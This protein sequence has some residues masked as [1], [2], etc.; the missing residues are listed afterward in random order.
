M[1]TAA[2][3]QILA[4]TR[5]AFVTKK[6]A[7]DKHSIPDK[8][9]SNTARSLQ[10]VLNHIEAI[11]E[12][13][14]LSDH[15]KVEAVGAL[16]KG[17]RQ[18]LD[19][20]MNQPHPEEG[21]KVEARHILASRLALTKIHNERKSAEVMVTAHAFKIHGDTYGDPHYRHR[22]ANK[23]Q[24]RRNG[25]VYAEEWTHEWRL[26]KYL[27][28]SDLIDWDTDHCERIL[29]YLHDH[30]EAAY[31]R[32][33]NLYPDFIE[34]TDETEI[35]SSTSYD[36]HHQSFGNCRVTDRWI[37]SP[38]MP[39]P[40]KPLPGPIRGTLADRLPAKNVHKMFQEHSDKSFVLDSCFY[41]VMC[42]SGLKD[43]LESTNHNR[44][45]LTF[46]GMIPGQV[47][48]RVTLQQM[49]DHVFKPML[50]EIVGYFR[51]GSLAF[52]WHP[53]MMGINPVTRK[54]YQANSKPRGLVVV[55]VHGDH[56]T[57]V[58]HMNTRLPN[59]ERRDLCKPLKPPREYMKVPVLTPGDNLKPVVSCVED[60]LP[61]ID[62]ESLRSVRLCYIKDDDCLPLYF[63]LRQ[64]G[65]DPQVDWN[66]LSITLHLCHDGNSKRIT[67]V[68]PNTA[69]ERALKVATAEELR[70]LDEHTCKIGNSLRNNGNVCSQE[71]LLYATYALRRPQLRGPLVPYGPEEHL[72]GFDLVK[73]FAHHGAQADHHGRFTEFDDLVPWDGEIRATDMYL[74]VDNL[75]P[76]APWDELWRGQQVGIFDGDTVMHPV[77]LGFRTSYRILGMWRPSSLVSNTSGTT[78]G[79]L[80][81]D[82]ELR[83]VLKKQPPNSEHGKAEIVWA[84]SSECQAY[85]TLEQAMAMCIR[86]PGDVNPRVWKRL[87][88]HEPKEEEDSEKSVTYLVK[89]EVRKRLRNGFYVHKHRLYLSQLCFQKYLRS[90]MESCGLQ[91]VRYASDCTY[92][93]ETRRDG[94]KDFALAYPEYFAEPGKGFANAG[95]IRPELVRFKLDIG[96]E[97]DPKGPIRV[98]LSAANHTVDE[99]RIKKFKLPKLLSERNVMP[100]RANP[101]A[102]EITVELI[103]FKLRISKQDDPR[104]PVRVAIWVEHLAVDDPTFKLTVS[105]KDVMPIRV[106]GS[107][108]T[109]SKAGRNGEDLVLTPK[110]PHPNVKICSNE[111]DLQQLVEMGTSACREGFAGMESVFAGGRKSAICDEV[112]KARGLQKD[113]VLFVCYDHATE[114][115]VRTRH[116]VWNMPDWRVCSMHKFVGRTPAHV[117]VD[118]T[119]LAGVKAIVF[120][121]L[122]K[123]DTSLI[124]LANRRAQNFAFGREVD[125]SS[126]NDFGIQGT[127][128]FQE[129]RNWVLANYDT[130]QISPPGD[131]P[132]NVKDY[133][134][135]RK[136][137]VFGSMFRTVIYQLRNK[138]WPADCQHMASSILVDCFGLALKRL[139]RKVPDD[140]DN[141]L[142]Q[143]DHEGLNAMDW[144]NK[145]AKPIKRLEDAPENSQFVAY[146]RDSVS[147]A[148]KFLSKGDFTVEV[149]DVLRCRDRTSVKKVT[150]QVGTYWKVTHK[151]RKDTT[152]RNTLYDGPATL[153]KCKTDDEKQAF[154]KNVVLIDSRNTK[155]LRHF[156]LQSAITGHGMMGARTDKPLV[157]MDLK[158]LCS[159]GDM[160]TANKWI[161]TTLFRVHHPQQLYYLDEPLNPP[162]FFKY[163]N[164]KRIA[165]YQ[166][167]D[168]KA[169]RPVHPLTSKELFGVFKKQNRFCAAPT[170]FSALDEATMVADR[171]DIAIG[172]K[173]DNLQFCCHGCNASLGAGQRHLPR[174]SAF[175]TDESE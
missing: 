46:E 142:T 79:A 2:I 83:P 137:M 32:L 27:V 105:K 65:Y 50:W 93:R 171:K 16:F 24:I 70:R 81:E 40:V 13:S 121:E 19:D 90:R 4:Q 53:S 153:A 157:I 107:T 56:V 116:R 100:I 112:C 163:F 35:P 97:D 48:G 129:E 159:G 139:L 21:K 114:E 143:I 156:D 146:M 113:E 47:G 30:D 173:L 61:Y 72:F 127:P 172:H 78:I 11:N 131:V 119:D 117:E 62:D 23:R 3:K 59:G 14:S 109:I 154:A 125:E 135:Y 67:I 91:V 102:R 138:T 94:L 140:I 25:N 63:K 168:R 82:A 37:D 106:N 174:Q 17:H 26:P 132:N 92:F 115:T 108:V 110:R 64:A 167:Q 5:P 45:S 147:R 128:I 98:Y 43:K 76:T 111:D 170:C 9:N 160:R 80:W 164:S 103:R 29:V 84:K 18:W 75:F 161:M 155:Q 52:H 38:Y 144:I 123:S 58:P 69:E 145:Y 41:K 169:G 57:A 162:Q 126:P 165:S 86:K 20:R 88:C 101:N 36:A 10:Y 22:L 158:W 136:D 33:V 73:S 15:E 89:E 6:V 95:K 34:L 51:D 66:G 120:E 99:T 152:I 7:K 8:E 149:G 31:Q 60:L 122:G 55:M 39:C 54:P 49:I 151:N 68:S 118:K 12:S 85:D 166:E 175:D 28:T 150:V 148:N 77:G 133:D 71:D 104:G 1:V 87:I 130:L 134:E 44:V 96:K 124:A 42:D 141:M 74:C